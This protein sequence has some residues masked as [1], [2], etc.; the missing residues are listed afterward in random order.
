MDEG[1]LSI[2]AGVYR[3]LEETLQQHIS[4][5]ISIVSF[6][7]MNITFSLISCFQHVIYPHTLNCAIKPPYTPPFQPPTS[8]LLPHFLLY[9]A[10]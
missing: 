1:H 9:C 10:K 4:I 8:P 7:H 5:L 3:N 6:P 2:E